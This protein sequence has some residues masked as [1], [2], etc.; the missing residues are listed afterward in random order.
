MTQPTETISKVI[1]KTG[2]LQIGDRLTSISDAST[3]HSNE[4]LWPDVNANADALGV[5]MNLLLARL[6]QHGLIAD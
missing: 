2:N 3:S 1:D 5:Q 6:R 4:N